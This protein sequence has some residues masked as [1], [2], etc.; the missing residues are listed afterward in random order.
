MG[1]RGWLAPG[2]RVHL[3]GVAGTAMASLAGMLKESGYHVT[4][5]DTGVYPPMSTQLE[6]LGIVV[7]DGYAA[8]HL[9]PAPDLVV[10]GNALSRGN[11]EVEEVLNRGLRYESMAVVV[12]ELY[13]RRSESLVVAGTH[14]KTTTTSMLAWILECAGRQPGFLIGGVPQNFPQSFRRP[15]DQNGCFVIEGDEYD[16]AFFDKGPKFMHYL[17]RAVVL[18]SV[19]FDHADIYKD[20]D[21]VKTAFQRLVNL[22]PGKGVVVAWGGSP[23]VAEC[24]KIAK[25][26]VVTYGISSGDWSARELAAGENGMRFEVWRGGER[27]FTAEMK[28]A[29][30]HNVLNALGACAMASH[31]GVA[32]DALRQA[33]ATFEGVKRRLE[34]RGEENGVTVID[35]FAHHPTAIQQTL[36]AARRRYAGRRVWAILEPRS[37]TL[38]R[39]VFEAELVG[40]LAEA[41]RVVIAA[42]YR[43]ESIPESERLEP[44][45]VIDGLTAQ[46][47]PALLLPTAD[48]IVATIGP[49]LQKGDVVVVMSNGGFGGIHE[50]LLEK[51]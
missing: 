6:Q 19:E 25:C 18:T 43:P 27:L 29:G 12:K 2:A 17:P 15:S 28:L 23:S 51:L 47:K 32:P 40:A 16:T 45:R 4:G 8:A 10:I 26:P 31:H 50:R 21:Q 13:L 34:V 22:V 5:S 20:L 30:E 41:D 39:R 3:I 33:L 42:V 48:E 35:D 46:S 36:R 38:R 49:Q 44:Q 11:P 9:D 14:G 37:N 24:V 1:L 7:Q